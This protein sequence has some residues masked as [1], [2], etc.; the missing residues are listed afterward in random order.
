MREIEN[1]KENCQLVFEKLESLLDDYIEYENE[2]EHTLA[3]V[4]FLLESLEMI[5]DEAE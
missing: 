4:C 1:L 3:K 5:L 2:K